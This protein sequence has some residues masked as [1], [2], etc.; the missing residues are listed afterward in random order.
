VILT[1]SGAVFA[2]IFALGLWRWTDRRADEAAWSSLASFQPSA[3][4]KFEIAMIDELPGPAQ[5]FFRF[6]ITP[7][8]PL[9]TV[10]DICM[11]G[12]FSLGSKAEPNYMPMRAE[13]IIA[14]PRGFVWRLHAG[15]RVWFDG[16]D[17]ANDGNSWSRFWLL[18]ILPVARAGNNE[19]HRRS[20]F[21]RY[22]AEA[23]FWTPAALL[24]GD[25]VRWEAI[26]GLRVRV[27][28]RH[29]GLEQAVE[30]SVDAEG[31]LSK[32]A[33]QRWS[34]ANSEK[35][36]KSQ[37]FGGHLS[38]YREFGGFRLPTR[39]EAGNFFDTDDYF[40]FFKASVTSVRFPAGNAK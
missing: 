33:L 32:V 10:A 30:L 5:R 28:V 11:E 1:L 3:P 26:D 40:P 18:G 9:Y 6:A 4:A 24:P 37:P 7:G 38:A 36:F 34:D 8:T 29:L 39:I 16:S 15:D 31:K 25:N 19:D 23:V 27:I 20:A 21:G 2:A 22:I 14:A 13:Q 12:E 17:G 35:R